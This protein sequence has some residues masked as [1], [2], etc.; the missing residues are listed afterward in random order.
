MAGE[1]RGTRGLSKLKMLPSFHAH[2]RAL[3]TGAR[4]WR[5]SDSLFCGGVVY[6]VHENREQIHAD[7]RQF[8]EWEAA[9]ELYAVATATTTAKTE[10]SLTS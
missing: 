8:R 6:L 10:E 4:V 2:Y 7:I 9:G 5:T 1:V 3:E